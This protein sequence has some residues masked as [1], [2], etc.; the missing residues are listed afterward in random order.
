[1]EVGADSASKEK[2]ILFTFMQIHIDIGKVITTKKN[3][4]ATKIHPQGPSSALGLSVRNKITQPVTGT[5]S[6]HPSRSLDALC[7]AVFWLYLS[8][9]VSVSQPETPVPGLTSRHRLRDSANA[10]QTQLT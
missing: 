8:L 1:M 7:L 9:L 10:S 2:E 6:L 5:S 4:A 3:E